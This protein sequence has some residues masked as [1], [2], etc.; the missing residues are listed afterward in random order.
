MESSHHTLHRTATMEVLVE[1]LRSV[2]QERRRCHGDELFKYKL[3]LQIDILTTLIEGMQKSTDPLSYAQLA[4]SVDYILK[5]EG[6]TYS[7]FIST[8]TNRYLSLL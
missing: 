6:F 7:Q 2:Q 3:S 1:E 4:A 5:R 8:Q